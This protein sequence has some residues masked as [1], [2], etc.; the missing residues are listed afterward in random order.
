MRINH[1]IHIPR[2]QS[3]SLQTRNNIRVRTHRLSRSNMFL[4]RLDIPLQIFSHTEIKYNA[5]E[6]AVDGIS[7]LDQETK[8]RHSFAGVFG[9]GGYELVFWEGEVATGEGVEGDCC[10]AHGWFKSEGHGFR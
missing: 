8:G 10:A 6:F 3:T 2:F 4:N 7:M 9:D 5:C 1:K